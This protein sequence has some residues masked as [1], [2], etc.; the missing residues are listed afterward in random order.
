MRP[1]QTLRQHANQQILTDSTWLGNQKLSNKLGCGALMSPELSMLLA[2]CFAPKGQLQKVV[3]SF[4]HDQKG[5]WRELCPSGAKCTSARP[6]NVHRHGQRHVLQFSGLPVGMSQ[7]GKLSHGCT[8]PMFAVLQT[9]PHHMICSSCT[10]QGLQMFILADM[11]A[12]HVS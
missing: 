1:L 10:L 12:L 4:A 2:E 11:L 7:V 5:L 9:W 3:C 6:A 8:S